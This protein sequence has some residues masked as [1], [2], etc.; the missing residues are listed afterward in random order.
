MIAIGAEVT[1]STSAKFTSGRSGTAVVSDKGEDRGDKRLE[2]Y[3][4]M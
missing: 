3:F 2:V 1:Y 4:L